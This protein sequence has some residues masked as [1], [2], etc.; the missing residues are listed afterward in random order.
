[1]ITE[2][3]VQWPKKYD[4]LGV[5]VSATTYDEAVKALLNAAHQRLPAVASCHAVHAVVVAS[6]NPALRQAVN[7]FQIITADGQPVR[8]ALN[9]LHKTSLRDRVYGPEFM[10]RICQR[11]AEEDLPIYLYGSTAEVI[12]TLRANL[13]ARYPQLR[14]AGAEAPP[15][16]RLSSEEEE[17]L[18]TRINRSGARIVFVGLGCPKQDIFAYEHRQRIQ[19]V[20]VCVGAAFDFHAGLKRM[21]PQWMQRYGLEWF[22][23]VCQEPRRLWQR[24]LLGNSIFIA[25]LTAQ[26]I[27]K[28]IKD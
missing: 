3:T 6:G 14:L 16:R 8:W 15:F 28:G 13:L 25:K 4:I 7:T 24:Y 27:W 5:R 20:Q 12:D 9:L 23:R 19:A 17:E 21:A 11:A 26:W 2:A 10:L 22:F 18:V 1:M